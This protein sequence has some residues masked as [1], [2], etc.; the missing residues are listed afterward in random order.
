MMNRRI[1]LR[2]V[3]LTISLAFVPQA[4]T[5]CGSS[6]PAI[7][8]VIGKSVAQWLAGLALDTAASVLADEIQT[9][10]DGDSSPAAAA[11]NTAYYDVMQEHFPNIQGSQVFQAANDII[12]YG[13]S[14]VN[15]FNACAPFI[16]AQNPSATGYLEGPGIVGIGSL[17]QDVIAQQPNNRGL[18]I[19]DAFLPAGNVQSNGWNFKFE[20]NGN[21]TYPSHLGTVGIEYT[22][23]NQGSGRVAVTASD[24]RGG[25]LAEGVYDLQYS[26]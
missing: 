15:G 18:V 14:A 13:A 4:L 11:G 1:F 23:Q 9:W 24:F 26:L 7:I 21:A 8:P 17:A 5:G 3:G 6:S 16:P 19:A 25:T 20:Q 22:N 12:F 10:I 2:R